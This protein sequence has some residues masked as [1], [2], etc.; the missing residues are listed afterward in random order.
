VNVELTIEML[1]SVAGS[2][3]GVTSGQTSS[4]LTSSQRPSSPAPT[5]TVSPVPPGSS[6]GTSYKSSPFDP[7]GV[8]F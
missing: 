7:V 8:R 6:G 3:I 4:I 5:G 2:G 1:E